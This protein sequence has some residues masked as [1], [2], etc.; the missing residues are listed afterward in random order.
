MNFA[1]LI[2]G[3]AALIFNPAFY[4]VLALA[5]GTSFLKGCQY[6]QHELVELKGEIAAK[7]AIVI[8]K[9]GAITEKVVTVFRDRIK[10]VKEI[11]DANAAA[12]PQI[13]TPEID[14]AFP[15]P[16]GAIRLLNCAAGGTACSPAGSDGEPSGVALD[17]VLA[18]TTE[19]LS[20]CRGDQ[21]RLRSLQDWVTQQ[22]QVKP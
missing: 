7:S 8:T 9:Q 13:I 15:V 10:I 2:S 19:N 5:C 22:S 12:L 18:T 4:I 3:G 21:E 17:S 1:S 16:V 6:E 14:R 11:S 20:T